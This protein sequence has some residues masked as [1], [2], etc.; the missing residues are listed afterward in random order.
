MPRTSGLDDLQGALKAVWGY[1]ALRYHQ[2]RVVLAAVRGRDCLAL[3]PTGGGKSI[4]F[5]L[6]ALTLSGLT[7]VISPLIALM[8]DQVG[9]LRRRG[10]AAAFVTSAQSAARRAAVWSAVGRHAVKLLYVAPERLAEVGERLAGERPALLA[11]DEAHCISEWGHEFRPHYRALGRH[12]QLLGMPPTLAVTATATPETA[13]D[14]VRVLRLRRP[15]IVRQPF[16]RPNLRFE[17]RR[18]SRESE[19]MRTAA[20]LLRREEGTAIV[21]VPTRNRT[22]GTT[23]VL[24]WWG[25]A[26]EPYHAGLPTAARRE[27]LTRFVA[28]DI[29][30]MVATNAFGMG[31]DKP[32]VRLVVH[33][34]I[35]ARPE[36]YYQEAGRAGRDGR[37]A[38]CAM[39]WV[40]ADLQLATYLSGTGPAAARGLAAM[41]RYV[42]TRGCRRRLLLEY[43]GDR[44]PACSG[45]DRCG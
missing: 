42:R 33:L 34:G 44:A 17:V 29:R 13:R 9:A 10:I 38:R 24:R 3:L 25:V 41:R 21:Y 23:R 8:Q 27:L 20:D 4:C 39:L 11:V 37:P 12:R 18:L 28:G 1:D 30:V 36:A 6:P 22:D 16:D 14:I 7:L 35:P 19:R 45:C 32:D 43:L 2:R 15:V 5:Q 26:A 31:I 40:P